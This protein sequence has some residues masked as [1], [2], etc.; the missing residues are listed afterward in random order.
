MNDLENIIARLSR[1]EEQNR[2]IIAMLSGRWSAG[3]GY[4]DPTNP[5]P[6]QQSNSW[7][8]IDHKQ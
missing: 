3:G 4:I 5:F 7:S 8:Q 2:Q 6:N 1:I